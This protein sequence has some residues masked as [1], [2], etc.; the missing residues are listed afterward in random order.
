MHD[1]QA[2]RDREASSTSRPSRRPAGGS[3]A[4]SACRNCCWRRPG[5]T[6]TRAATS[7]TAAACCGSPSSRNWRP[8]S[9]RSISA[10]SF[11]TS[12]TSSSWRG[13][14]PSSG[15]GGT[16]ARC[17]TSRTSRRSTSYRL[18]GTD[19]Y[20]QVAPGGNL[21]HGTLGNETYTNKADTYGLMLVGR[22]PGHHQRRPGGHYHGA[23][24]A[25]PRVGTEDQR[26]LLDHLPQQRGVLHR[27][28]QELPHRREHRPGHRRPDGGGGGLH[29][30]LRQRRQA[31]RRHAG[32]LPG[33]HV[34]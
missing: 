6:A 14:S 25:G 34:P 18:I 12:P 8:G 22:P 31:D 10:G 33:A 28:G 13:S 5:P 27:G 20:E 9:P 16:S 23:P 7:A 21:K 19:Q 15:P 30:P 4:G 3:A 11:R 1:G 24:E 26:R 17:G 29:G 2:R 32:H